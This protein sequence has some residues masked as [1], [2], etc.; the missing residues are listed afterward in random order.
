LEYVRQ[1]DQALAK[2]LKHQNCH[3]SKEPKRDVALRLHFIQATIIP[4][5][6][7]G[8]HIVYDKGV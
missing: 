8:W 7:Y 4:L 2:M 5:N 6:W 1:V 3:R